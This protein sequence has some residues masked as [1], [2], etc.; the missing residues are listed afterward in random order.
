[1]S[2]AIL[3]AI[4]GACM[5]KICDS[6][7]KVETPSGDHRLFDAFADLLFGKGEESD[8]D[9][10]SREFKC[11]ACCLCMTPIPM[12]VVLCYVFKESDRYNCWTIEGLD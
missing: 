12:I 4:L 8:I 10:D 1:M 7:F 6:V 9:G 2:F 3:L 5:A 11:I